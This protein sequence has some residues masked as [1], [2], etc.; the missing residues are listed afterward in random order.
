MSK[1]R[2]PGRTALLSCLGL[3]LCLTAPAQTVKVGANP[4]V[5]E[6]ARPT[7]LEGR[8]AATS[9]VSEEDVG[10]VLRALGPAVTER[11]ASGTTVEI[12]N[13][14]VFRVVRV[15]EHKDLVNG[16]PA[17]IPAKNYV[18]YLPAGGLNEAANS[19]KAVPAASVPPF[20]YVLIGNEVPRTRTENTRVPGIRTR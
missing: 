2:W 1:L 5:K 4:K 11:L 19:D 20:E 12:P 15:E 14:G 9:K 6:G 10:K 8:I 17:T 16:R 13:L 18:E 3:L 7:T